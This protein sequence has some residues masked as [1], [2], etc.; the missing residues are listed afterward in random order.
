ML[1]FAHTR[2]YQAEA[3]YDDLLK[4]K[5]DEEAISKSLQYNAE[6]V[7][8]AGR[9]GVESLA[10]A[11]FDELH[12]TMQWCMAHWEGADADA[13][14]PQAS[15]T[16][17]QSVASNKDT[18]SPAAATSSPVSVLLRGLRRVVTIEGLT[19]KAF[20]MIAEFVL[21]HGQN[22]PAEV[23]SL[24]K[25]STRL[26]THIAL[27]VAASP[28]SSG[29]EV[30]ANLKIDCPAC[31]TSTVLGVSRN[32]LKDVYK[33]K[34]CDFTNPSSAVSIMRDTIEDPAAI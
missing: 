27:L 4:I 26:A 22:Q 30:Y 31:E 12:S 29:L 3:G 32:T 10:R 13:D 28:A 25:Q 14:A 19:D 21:L 20:D 15:A 7:S 24:I 2:V 23:S 9:Y 1:K 5:A 34:E 18:K 16:A 8:V 33:C 11:A 17:G 6:V